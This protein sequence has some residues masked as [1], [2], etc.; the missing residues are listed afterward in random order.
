VSVSAT[1]L[2]TVD[3]LAERWQ[4]LPSQ[5]YR[6]ARNG[7]LPTV[8]LGRYRRWRLEDVEQFERNGG[9]ADE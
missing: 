7:K 3:E 6:L 8:K 5:V 2:L 9:T 4:L 1:R